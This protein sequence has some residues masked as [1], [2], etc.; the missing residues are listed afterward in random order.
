MDRCPA[1]FLH[2]RPGKEVKIYFPRALRLER[3]RLL[4][5]AALVL[6]CSSGASFGFSGAA[7]PAPMLGLT[8]SAFQRRSVAEL[9][10]WPA[11]GIAQ[12]HALLQTSTEVICEWT[13]RHARLRND[14]Y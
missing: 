11:S 3:I 12:L 6:L 9:S 10:G 14:K 7:P 1:P 4:A 2:H 13:C 8:V 5:G